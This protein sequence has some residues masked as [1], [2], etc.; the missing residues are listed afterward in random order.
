MG[1]PPNSNTNRQRTQ[2]SSPHR[3]GCVPVTRNVLSHLGVVEGQ[4]GGRAGAPVAPWSGKGLG[5]PGPAPTPRVFRSH[6]TSISKIFARTNTKLSNTITLSSILFLLNTGNA[7]F[8]AVE[9]V[10]TEWLWKK[11]IG[12]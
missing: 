12:D 9:V 3:D 7:I 11:R 10:V 4:P 8:F 2:P 6:F 1:Y 5:E